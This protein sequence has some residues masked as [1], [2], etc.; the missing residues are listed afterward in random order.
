MGL[1]SV[2]RYA[3][4]DRFPALTKQ[5]MRDCIAVLYDLHNSAV[6]D[7]ADSD[8]GIAVINRDNRSFFFSGFAR[9]GGF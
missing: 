4:S 9:R 8:R 6:G 2:C 1:V 7:K 3:L 5:S